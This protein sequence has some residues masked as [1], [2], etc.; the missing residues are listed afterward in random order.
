MPDLTPEVEALLAK[1]R[2]MCIAII[3]LGKLGP[4]GPSDEEQRRLS[5]RLGAVMSH[6]LTHLAIVYGRSVGIAVPHGPLDDGPL[7]MSGWEVNG[8]RL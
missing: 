3:E 5:M 7:D 6:E 1:A 4:D 2:E 8:L